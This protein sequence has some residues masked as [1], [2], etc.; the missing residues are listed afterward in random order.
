MDFSIITP[1]YNNLDYLKL[2]KASIEDQK[3]ITLEHIIVDGASSDGTVSWL[4]EMNG[5]VKWISEP[6]NGMYDAVNKGFTKAQGNILAYLNCDEQY[7]SG[8]LSYVKKYFEKNPH[9]DVL[10]GDFLVV[11]PDGN[12]SAF[13]KSF[14]P[15]VRYL[16]SNYLY[17]LTCTMFLRR[18]V[19]EKQK[20]N[21]S[22]KSIADVDF[23][24]NVIK[25][26]FRVEHIKKYLSIFTDTGN[27]LSG[28]EFSLNELKNYKS[29]LSFYSEFTNLPLKVLF[30]LEKTA[31]LNYW[32]KGS[33]DYSIYTMD[34][35]ANRKYFH[36]M[37]P[38]F[39]WTNKN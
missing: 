33:L 12:L 17:T 19:F 27:N 20:F 18:N 9:V 34:S 14:K 5:P 23:V 10:F 22:L 16:F 7:L 21:T 8:T 11:K 25:K 28:N 1:S 39:K 24:Y 35:E 31:N 32:H 29:N 37:K 13:R 3:G 15:K 2:C 26:G 6:D 30:Y 38:T 36:V 4:K